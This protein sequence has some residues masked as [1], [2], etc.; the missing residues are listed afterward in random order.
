MA[1]ILNMSTKAALAVSFLFAGI[2]PAKAEPFNN[3]Q[4]WN[5]ACN[6][7][8]LKR[9]GYSP[10]K[11]ELA[12]DIVWNRDANLARSLTPSGNDKGLRVL[13]GFTDTTQ[14]TVH[15]LMSPAT[16]KFTGEDT[17][18]GRYGGW[19]EAFG[20][21]I[22]SIRSDG[23]AAMTRHDIIYGG[24]KAFSHEGTCKI[25]GKSLTSDQ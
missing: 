4:I 24:I 23:S 16:A 15:F 11:E 20:P 25:S 2:A 14:N 21:T 9:D 7:S 5:F 13:N 10:D 1:G 19:V 17:K 6:L 8:N 3:H 12:L 22:I 18:N